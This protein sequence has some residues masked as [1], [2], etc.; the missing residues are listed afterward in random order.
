MERVMTFNQL[1]FLM[2]LLGVCCLDATQEF[3]YCS[4]FNKQSKYLNQGTLE[5]VRFYSQDEHNEDKK[6]ART[7]VF[8]KRPY[9][10]GIVVICHGFMCNKFDIGFLRTLFPTFHVFLFDFR[11]HGEC[12]DSNQYCTFGKNE[13]LDV[14]AAVNFLKKRKDLRGLPRFVYGFSMGAVAAIQAQGQDPTL[15]DGMVL[16]CP[17]DHS[18]NVIRKGLE[19]MTVTLFGYT[20]SIPGREFLEKYAYHPYI[21]SLLKSVL[22]TISHMDAT[23]TNTILHPVSTVDSIKKITVPIFLIHCKNDE[24]IILNAAFNLYNNAAGYKRLWITFGRRHF[25][26][27]FFSPEKY[28]YKINQFF[29]NIISGAYRTKIPAKIKDDTLGEL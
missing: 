5:Y 22:K 24:K 10:K 17:F 29:Y 1:F 26:S 6:I 21:Q 15:F 12:I 14:I 23:A 9:A 25:D 8:L 27:Y 18:D 16:D 11:A 4:F 2:T 28:T 13:A 7:G 3:D 19:N 20:F